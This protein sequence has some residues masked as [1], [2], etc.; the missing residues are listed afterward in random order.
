MSTMD[1]LTVIIPFFNGYSTLGRLLDSLPPEIPVLIVDDQSDVPLRGGDFARP[2]LKVIY[3]PDKGYFTGAANAGLS[4]TAGDVLVVN[5]DAYFT[6]TGWL[7]LIRQNRE[8]YGLIGEQPLG[9][10]PAFPGYVH[11]SFLFIRRDVIQTVGHLNAKLYPLW[12]S[13]GEYQLRACRAGFEVLPVANVPDFQHRPGRSGK[14][15][16]AM[17]T[18]IKREPER[19]AE[20]TRIPPEISVVIPCHNYGRYLPEAIDSLMTQTFQSFEVI[21]V[22]DASTDNSLE[23]AQ[24]LADPWKAIRVI[25]LQNNVGTAAAVNAGINQA[26]GKYIAR[27]DADDMMRPARLAEMWSLQMQNPHSFVFDDLVLFGSEMDK[28]PGATKENGEFVYHLPDYDFERLVHKNGVHAGIM[29]PKQAWVDTG[30]YP[31]DFRDGRDDW[32][33][34]VALGIKGYCGVKTGKPGYLYR[35][36]GQNRTLTNTRPADYQMFAEKMI[37]YFPD[38]YRGVRPMGCCGS[39]ISQITK[40]GGSQLPAQMSLNGL[41]GKTGFEILEY[42]GPSSSDM[43][44]WGPATKTRYVFGGTRRVGYVDARDAAGMLQ[45]GDNGRPSFRV[46]VKPA[47]QEPAIEIT[48]KEPA[49]E[50]VTE[51]PAVEIVTKEPVLAAVATQKAASKKRGVK[52]K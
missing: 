7:D 9:Q 34:N 27:L 6:G 3:S 13:T 50:I 44:W 11:G 1:N 5:Q 40:S 23:F 38:I 19:E 33:F 51:E 20:F 30:G 12:G 32:S 47:I 29:F 48:V 26:N 52:S 28:V 22:D 2:K 14:Y 21:I 31:V 46:Y 49:V 36:D 35:R 8:R 45:M 24:E 39:G 42:I 15:G 43:S 17:V 18:A 10:R 4:Y 41:P 37:R 16:P 25:H